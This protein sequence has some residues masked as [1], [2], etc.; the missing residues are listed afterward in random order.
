MNDDDVIFDFDQIIN[1]DLS[2]RL[3][4]EMLSDDPDQCKLDELWN[5][6]EASPDLENKKHETRDQES[7]S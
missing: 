3:F 4:S 1:D 7:Q 5:R 6:L 2:A